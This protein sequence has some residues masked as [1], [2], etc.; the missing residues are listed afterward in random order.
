MLPFL[1]CCAIQTVH[2]TICQ[3]FCS[4]KEK[5][6][7]SNHR[8]LTCKHCAVIYKHKSANISVDIAQFTGYNSMHSNHMLSQL[9]SDVLFAC[10]PLHTAVWGHVC[11]GGWG[12]GMVMMMMT[13]S[14]LDQQVLSPE[15]TSLI[16]SKLSHTWTNLS[17]LTLEDLQ[18]ILSNFA[19]P[20]TFCLSRSHP[21]SLIVC[22]YDIQSSFRLAGIV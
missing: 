18:R 17:S 8:P 19:I 13:A 16:P 7:K 9:A 2:P 1:I 20:H 14:M 15:S 4:L 3:Q 11:C 5:T 22:L 10:S 12:R 6:N 21:H